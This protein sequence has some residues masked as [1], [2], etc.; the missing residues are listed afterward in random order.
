M[1]MIPP[2][3][4]EDTDARCQIFTSFIQP[5]RSGLTSAQHPAIAADGPGFVLVD[6]DPNNARAVEPIAMIHKIYDRDFL[7]LKDKYDRRALDRLAEA[8][9]RA[10]QPPAAQ[11]TGVVRFWPVESRRYNTQIPATSVP[12]SR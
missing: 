8:A 6:G 3:N 1:D 7:I 9:R 12:P 4:L 10:A 11:R 5:G 2:F